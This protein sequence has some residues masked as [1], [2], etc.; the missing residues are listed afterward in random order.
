M[1]LSEKY[2]KLFLE[3]GFSEN[4]LE[5]VLQ[6]WKQS[7]RAYHGIS[8]LSDVLSQIE[9]LDIKGDFEGVP[10][11]D[12]LVLAAF[13]HD[14]VYHVRWLAIAPIGNEKASAAEFEK[15]SKYTTL[16][17][18]VE[19]R[20]EKI[21]LDTATRDVPNDELSQK[22]WYIDN[23]VL[24]RDFAGLLQWE[25]EIF[26]EWQCYSLAEYRKGRLQFLRAEIDRQKASCGTIAPMSNEANLEALYSYVSKFRPTIGVYPGSY[27]P[28]HIGHYNVLQKAEKIF[29]KVILLK[30]V[31][32]EKGI[33]QKP[34]S[35]I[36]PEVVFNREQLE[37]KGMTHEYLQLIEEM[38]G[39]AVLIRGLRNG[40]DLDYE[41]NQLRFTESFYPGV[42][43]AYIQ[44]DKEY[45][46]ISSSAIRNILKFKPEL[47]QTYLLQKQN[48]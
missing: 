17:P 7:H 6:A 21:I 2:Q 30:G 1:N 14:I 18:A 35:E 37:W 16:P 29:D 9:K 28:F 47:A 3:H 12:I 23:S 33:A 5:R 10:R 31:N 41:V 13:Y 46:H 4:E 40:K 24:Y 19:S 8:H 38:G 48:V 43:V 45:E 27:D 44:S 11:K 22:F 25:R 36:F 34:L 20:I 26:L 15:A 42:K 39:N 32:P